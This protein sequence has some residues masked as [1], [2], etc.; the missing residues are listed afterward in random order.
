ME[1]LDRGLLKQE[2]KASIKQAGGKV[3]LTTL[4]YLVIVYIVNILSVKIMYPKIDITGY[5][6]GDI[7][8]LAFY[9]SL[10]GSII[11]AALML[12]T[13]V[14]AFGFVIF[15]LNVSR[16]QKAE[17]GNLFDGFARF[18]KVIWLLLVQ[19]FFI[20][21]WSLLLFVPL[22][23]CLALSLAVPSLQSIMPIILI[24]M[25]LAYTVFIC[26]IALRYSMSEYILIDNP[27]IGALDCI[28][29][30]KRLMKGRKME[31]FILQLSFIGWELLTIIPFVSIY[32][33]P[34]VS[35]TCANFYNK[36]SGTET[37]D[38]DNTQDNRDP[39]ER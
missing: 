13:T 8:A 22:G 14:V 16:N 6:L 28:N 32:V 12:A 4:V 18:L 31:Y 23:I 34:Y 1:K 9:P 21:L 20:W 27:H 2:A 25:F 15:M 26:I 3:Y 39:W 7:N 5:I 10:L 11:Y 36:I 30:S 33:T 38:A 19:M 24:P 37:K 17:I 29:E 35:V